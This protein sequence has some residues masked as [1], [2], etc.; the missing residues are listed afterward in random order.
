MTAAR[1]Q[2][3]DPE[4]LDDS[5]K[6]TR[7]SQ[8]NSGGLEISPQHERNDS[9]LGVLVWASAGPDGSV[10]IAGLDGDSTPDEKRTARLGFAFAEEAGPVEPA[11]VAG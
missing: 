1:E 11:R 6:Q 2:T 3:A 4:R 10:L 8:T 7:V 5:S 9:R